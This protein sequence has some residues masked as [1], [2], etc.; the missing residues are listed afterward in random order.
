MSGVLP[1]A[2]LAVLLVALALAWFGALGQRKLVKPDEGR[3]G[4]IP[5]EMVA[6]GVLLAGFL[7]AGTLE[8]GSKTAVAES[9]AQRAASESGEA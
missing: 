8:R 5:R 7:V 3:Y 9:R 1:R 2:A 6:S 4:E